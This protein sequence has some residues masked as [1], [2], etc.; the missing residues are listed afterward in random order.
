[1]RQIADAISS[2]TSSKKGWGD[3]RVCSTG[4]CCVSLFIELVLVCVRKRLVGLRE[5][6]SQD[7]EVLKGLSIEGAGPQAV[8]SAINP[9]LWFEP[10]GANQVMAAEHLALTY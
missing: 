8:K 2:E 10:K 7:I 6:L 4:K 1:M 3:E 5:S 9:A